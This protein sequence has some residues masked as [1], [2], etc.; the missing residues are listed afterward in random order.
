MITSDRSKPLK[1]QFSNPNNHMET[2]SPN[3]EERFSEWSIEQ[4][5]DKWKHL[6]VHVKNSVGFIQERLDKKRE[7]LKRHRKMETVTEELR[8]H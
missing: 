3:A 7:F 6:H 2:T 1:T 4:N 8:G 5:T